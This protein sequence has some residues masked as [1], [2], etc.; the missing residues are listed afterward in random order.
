MSRILFWRWPLLALVLVIIATRAPTVRWG[1]ALAF[2]VVAMQ[3][4][5]HLLEPDRLERWLGS[6]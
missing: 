4:A 1:F 3:L 5:L 6:G 2:A